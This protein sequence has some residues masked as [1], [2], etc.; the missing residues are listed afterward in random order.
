M[1]TD[2]EQPTEPAESSSILSTILWTVGFLALG[3]VML[4]YPDAMADQNPRKA[5]GKLLAWVW[6]KPAG[7]VSLLL[8][9]VIGA[10]AFFGSKKQTA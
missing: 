5:I 3:F 1:Q 4:K 8:G 2:T 7:I 10:T 9:V 6:G